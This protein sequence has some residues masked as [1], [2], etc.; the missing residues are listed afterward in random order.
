MTHRP[1]IVIP[2]MRS[3]QV[4]GLRREGYVMA[5]RIADCVLRAGGEPLL[6]AP[7]DPNVALGRLDAFDG[8]LIPGGRDVDPALYSDSERN[9]RTDEP[10]EVQDQHDLQ[11]AREAVARG[12]P[13]LA[14][15][16]GMQVVNV[17]LG[18][19]L[20]QHLP[21]EGIHRD[22]FH[23]V[24]LEPGTCVVE[25][26]GAAMVEVSSYH[27]QA[28]DR[29]GEGLRVTGT[30]SDGC[31]EVLEHVSAPLLAVQWH[32]EDDAHINSQQ[33]A[34]FDQLVELAAARGATRRVLT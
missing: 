30:A 7:L 29:V 3:P 6:L 20:V 19:T 16:R 31:I 23:P 12:L 22:G 33:Q 4:S 13:I 2:A 21:D 32:P 14:I 34:L 9:E 10:D 24:T 18:G 27:H 15:C 25:V 11:V 5:Q 26:M 28:V 1:L 17:A 8:V